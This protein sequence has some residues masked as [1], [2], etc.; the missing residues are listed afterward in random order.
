LVAR[1]AAVVAA[2][3]VADD[4]GLELHVDVRVAPPWRP[5][6]RFMNAWTFFTSPQK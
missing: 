1:A 3:E 5:A 6:P 4:A 2:H